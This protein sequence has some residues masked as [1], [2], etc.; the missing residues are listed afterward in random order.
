MFERYGQ[1]TRT[2]IFYAAK[3]ARAGSGY[4]E[5]EHLLLGVMRAS[6][7][8]L[9]SAFA[10][11]GLEQEF[12][13]GR[14]TSDQTA[15]A[16]ADIPL[17]NAS[18]RILAYAAEE[19]ARINSWEIHCGHLLLGILR[20]ADGVA[21]RFLVEHGI[22]LAKARQAVARLPRRETSD[23]AQPAR[24]EIPRSGKLKRNFWMEWVLQVGLLVF[25]GLVLLRSH[26][27]SKA[28][29][30][31][32]GVWISAVVVWLALVPSFFLQFRTRRGEPATVLAFVFGV[33]C[34]LLLYGW[35]VVLGFAIYRL[36]RR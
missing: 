25:L 30:I 20:E 27:G 2:A 31:I 7:A 1:D 24:S 22:D 28:L 10:L 14:A 3:E 11:N 18:K 17:T 32:A 19:A 36:V 13:A 33:F 5:P 12:R 4:I 35:I 29:L 26:V 15:A 16:A 21:A 23:P 6:E 34:Q 8:G 9:S